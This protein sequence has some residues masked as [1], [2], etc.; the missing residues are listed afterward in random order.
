M[1]SPSDYKCSGCKRIRP[2]K[3]YGLKNNGER[4]KTCVRCRDR[5]SKIFL[6]ARHAR[7]SNNPFLHIDDVVETSKL[8]GYE[9]LVSD[10][11]TNN[12]TMFNNMY[13][14]EHI[15]HYIERKIQ[16]RKRCSS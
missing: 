9:A 12:N 11:R 10:P 8:Y 4:Y 14:G 6:Q 2:M 13:I 16:T 15:D 3:D 7:A 1:T 5:N